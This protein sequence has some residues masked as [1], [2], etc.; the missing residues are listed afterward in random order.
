MALRTIIGGTL[1]IVIA[2][3]A[4]TVSLLGQSSFDPQGGEYRLAGVLPG[5]QIQGR[6]AL[7][8]SGG[9]V[10][11]QDNYVDGNGLG[12]GLMRLGSSFN[13]EFS[14]VRINHSTAGNQENP[15]V[16][17]LTDRGAAVVWQGETAGARK[18][19]AQFLRPDGTLRFAA[20]LVVSSAQGGMKIQPKVAA[21]PHGGAV[22]AW[23]SFE[24]D[25]AES[26]SRVMARMQGVF[27]R[28]LG[29]NG[30]FGGAE[31]QVNQ[32]V[33]F[34]QRNPAVAG[35]ADGRLVFVWVSEGEE[36][37]AQDGLGVT[38][39]TRPVD[40]FARL[41]SNG[42]TALGNEFKV[43]S[44]S[45]NICAQP[46]V[47]A[48]QDGGFSVLWNENDLGNRED[49]W[50]IKARAFASDGAALGV[51]FPVNSH[52]YG[53]QVS[54]AITSA[55]GEQLAVW[56]SYAQDGSYEGIYGQFLRREEKL[57]QELKISTTSV[58][59]QI[60]PAVAGA[61]ETGFVALWSSFVGGDTSVDLYAQRYL[62]GVPKPAAPVV[63]AISQN[64]LSITWPKVEGFDVASYELYEQGRPEP[65]ITQNNWWLTPANLLPSTSRYYQVAYR[66]QDGRLSPLSDPGAGRTWGSDGDIGTGSEPDGLPDDWQLAHWPAGVFPP[67][68]DDSDGDGA[69]NLAEFLAGTD[70]TDA[71]DVLRLRLD[72][73]T[74]GWM[75]NW[76]TKAGLIY[77]LQKSTDFKS[78]SEVGGNRFAVGS[79]DTQNV[80]EG[81]G[82]GYFRVIRIR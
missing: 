31:F 17:V 19:L 43:N 52:L 4:T 62:V 25:D 21:L 15:D 18:I 76:N 9:Y 58:S 69:S 57:G 75:V 38:S 46:S 12:I 47:T 34:N 66:L 33:R 2:V 44:S 22:V 65:G 60:L 26:F 39:M 11:W 24:Q 67:R 54:P 16:A 13:P 27:G 49:S 28:V 45:T 80:D 79:Q 5:E 3:G 74:Y 7:G 55:G 1:P 30:G 41:F 61:G 20:D 77:Q 6:I 48:R 23:S 8:P 53:D 29:A 32:R 63:S 81:N 78:W 37:L 82:L 73:G 64:R 40:I 70:P 36:T 59:R 51:A 35:L 50:D 14:P 71:S 72:A 68:Q 56:A 10:V 42:G